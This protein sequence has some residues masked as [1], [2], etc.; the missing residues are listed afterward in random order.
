MVSVSSSTTGMSVRSRTHA[1][2]GRTLRRLSL[3][4]TGA[5]FHER[6]LLIAKPGLGPAHDAFHQ[7]FVER[8]LVAAAVDRQRGW[9]GRG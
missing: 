4:E 9:R 3:T 5:A 7:S 8:R 1:E 2:L 6:R